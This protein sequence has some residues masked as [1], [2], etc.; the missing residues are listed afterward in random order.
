MQ[1]DEFLDLLN[2]DRLECLAQPE[3]YQIGIFRDRN[4]GKQYRVLFASV[5][6]D[7]EEL[8][9]FEQNI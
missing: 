4:T 3:L 6:L 5:V 8:D 9:D 7:V 1:P 2:A